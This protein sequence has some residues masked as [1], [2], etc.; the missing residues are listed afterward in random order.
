M[1]KLGLIGCGNWAQTVSNV[2]L[3]N[4]KFKL[5]IQSY[6]RHHRQSNVSGK[7]DRETIRLIKQHYKDM[8]TKS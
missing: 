5:L 2:I 6:Q 3:K 8:L 7:I 1:Y 4:N